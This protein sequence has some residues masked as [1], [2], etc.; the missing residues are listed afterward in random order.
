MTDEKVDQQK[1]MDETEMEK[2]EEEEQKGCQLIPTLLN[3]AKVL[4]AFTFI[5]IFIFSIG[6]LSDSFQ[7]LGGAFLNEVLASVQDILSIPYC[8]LCLGILLTVLCQSSSTSTSIFI[9]LVAADLFTV[10]QGIY[11]IMGSNIG[12]SITSTL[13][14]FGNV[15][16]PSEFRNSVACAV[17]AA[18][19]NWSTVF[20]LLP[21]EMWFGMIEE[22][23]AAC[24]KN[25]D[26][27]QTSS[28]GDA[29]DPIKFITEPIQK[30]I[31]TINKEGLGEA[32][33][34][35][36][37][38]EYCKHRADE[39]RDYCETGPKCN[40]GDY[41]CMLQG[42]DFDCEWK[43]NNISTTWDY[44]YGST[45][46]EQEDHMFVNACWSDEAVGGVCLAIAFV[47][48]FAS[49]AGVVK[50]LKAVLEGSITDL[51]HKNIDKNLPYPF[52]WLTEY[53][54][55]LAG[56]TLTIAVQSSSI[57]LA[58]MTP[59]VG[60][61]VIS[62]ERCYPITVGSKIGTTITG[63]IAAFANTGPGFRRALQVSMSH[64]FFNGF[65]FLF[66][67]V[68]PITRRLPIAIANFSGDEA[69][70]YRWW[71]VMYTI[72]MFVLIPIILFAISVASVEAATAIWILI[73]VIMIFIATINTIREKKPGCLP[74]FLRSWKWLPK[75]MRSLE[76]Y[77]RY[78]CSVCFKNK[79]DVDIQENEGD[80]KEETRSVKDIVV[81][82]D[83]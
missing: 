41:V 74:P 34:T 78:I 6:L 76:P 53:L 17:L 72:F 2:E 35:G 68:V 66:F 83:L 11:C 59:I 47:L 48:M 9:T 37:F 81:T 79:N 7:V 46:T 22:I 28:A 21:L 36:S 69:K 24:T 82:S 19:F 32:N 13:V 1:E 55:I 58:I 75:F 60:I 77:D 51:I 45:C 12:T 23:T 10:S 39:C 64:I 57:I 61:G 67:F 29:V 20:I 15:A 31:I 56:F 8:G 27:N 26:Q 50:C 3:I 5:Y 18:A 25:I 65:G 38:V 44:F 42:D 73:P 52:G 14:A 71:A 40:G 80:N 43:G 54:Y 49:L 63:V 70:K 4:G 16:T 62:I 30:Y 33:Y